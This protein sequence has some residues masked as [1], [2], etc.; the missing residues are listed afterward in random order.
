VPVVTIEATTIYPRKFYRWTLVAAGFLINIC[1]GSI[2]SYSVFRQPLEGLWCLSSTESGL[3]FMVFLASFAF[4]MP[5][6]GGL[7]DKF[8]PRTAGI[9]GSVLVG[10]GWILASQSPDIYLL[11]VLYGVLGGVGVG[12]VYGAPIAVAARWFR[13]R[14]GAAMGLT[15]LGFGVSPLITAPIMS[16]LILSI[17][18]LQTFMYFGAGYLIILLILS[19]PLKFPPDTISQSTGKAWIPAASRQLGRGEMLRTRAFY[20]LWST[21]MLG[22]LSGLMAIGIAAPCGHEIAGIGPE[23]SAI[24]VSAFAVFNGVGRP[25]FGWLTDRLEPRRTAYISFCIIGFASTLL[26]VY[27][28]ENVMVYFVGFALLWLSLGGWL[29]IAPAATKIFFG[30]KHYGKNYGLVFT[31]YGVG[32]ILG[33]LSSG[34]LKDATGTYLTVFPVVSALS[35]AGLAIAHL[36]L[37]PPVKRPPKFGDMFFLR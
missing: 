31:A 24:A 8:G 28:R 36:A 21:F 1:L 4:T 5:L 15:L 14:A 12:I 11:T 34:W 30:T 23:V 22:C 32:A 7:L 17:G 26:Y 3:P 27:G 13:E 18:P 2:Y 37:K 29:A 6:A 10:L 9:L 20:A 25:L 33:M 16:S 19:I 35:V